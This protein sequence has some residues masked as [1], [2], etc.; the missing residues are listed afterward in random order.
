MPKCFSR[1]L[2]YSGQAFEDIVTEHL[3]NYHFCTRE[4]KRVKLHINR[5]IRIITNEHI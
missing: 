3:S 1:I 5:L 4:S 2:I